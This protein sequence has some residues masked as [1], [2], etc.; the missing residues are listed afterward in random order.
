[1]SLPFHGPAASTAVF[2]AAWP[3]RGLRRPVPGVY[4]LASDCENRIGPRPVTDDS[5]FPGTRLVVL[6]VAAQRGALL[7]VVWLVLAGAGGAALLAGLLAVPAATWMSLRLLPPRGG[8]R[9]GRLLVLLPGFLWRSLLGGVDVA[10]RVFHPGLPI[11]PGWLKE[12]V[13]LT[14]GGK[15][16]L[17]AELS[18][19]P[20]TLVA[21]SDGPRLLVHVLDTRH[22]TAEAVHVE[23]T[24][25]A[26]LMAQS[27]KGS[28]T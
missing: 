25:I 15:V 13:A 21:G 23:E 26:A 27:G 5:N 18:L 7:A 22:H 12:P 24:R 1:M 11:R 28:R 10:W 9:L 8:L 6:T 20:G 2:S 19:M 17:G 14:D 3:E 16:V 4:P